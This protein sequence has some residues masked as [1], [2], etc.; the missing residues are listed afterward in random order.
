MSKLT[1]ISV[2]LA[3]FFGL[4]KIVALVRQVIIARQFGLSAELDA[5]NVANN[6]PDLLYAMISGGALA[7][8]LIPVLSEAMSKDG[9]KAL[10]DLFSRIANIAFVATAILS[11]LIALFAP[12]L[13]GWRLG[14]APGFGPEQRLTVVNL[15]RLNLIATLIFSISGLAMAGLQANQH[16]LFP[17][18]SPILY[19][20]GQIIGALFLAPVW[21]V[22]GLV[23]GVIFGALLHLLIQVPALIKYRFSWIPSFGWNDYYVRKVLKLMGPRVI[24]I[25]LVQLVFIVRDN[26]ASHLAQGAVSALSYG[27][28]IQQLP[29]TLIGTAIGTAL[30]PTLS[31]MVSA[32]EDFKFA[33][34][35]EKA[36]KVLVVITIPVA[37]IAGLGLRPFIDTV[38]GLPAEQTDLLLWVTRGYLVGLMGHCLLE[39]A[40]RA[41][42]ARQNAIFPMLGAVLNLLI[43]ISLGNYL[44]QIMGAPGVSL[45]DSIAFTIQSVV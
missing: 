12:N 43:Y 27:W 37:V 6:L 45:T 30:L 40:A 11:I 41:F 35:L 1:K 20:V 21:G 32:K 4:D 33:D 9:R 17:A 19:N 28:M 7:I 18:M 24:S 3:V 36:F 14:I 16:F 10:W 31:E 25:F 42:Y 23:F 39:T 2:L 13:V 44:F 34:T 15:M 8:A 22:Y 5:F 29:E 38:F 26:L